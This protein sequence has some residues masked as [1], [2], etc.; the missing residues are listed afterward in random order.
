[1]YFKEFEIRWNDLDANM[2]LGNSSYIEFMSHTRMSFFQKKGI[3][4]D[5][6]KSFGL[7]PIVFY[8]H[9][10]YFKEILLNMPIKVSLEVSGHSE[11]G[12]FILIEHN[13]YDADGR[14]VANAEIMFSWIDLKTRKLGRI[15]EALLHI[16]ESFPRTADFK[17]LTNED[18]RKHQ[19]VPKDLTL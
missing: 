10:Y 4:L 1:M 16:I 9:V 7:G 6:M 18:T 2:H 19:K 17:F 13:F 11:D 14:N 5:K 15:P 3:G 12:R 8:E